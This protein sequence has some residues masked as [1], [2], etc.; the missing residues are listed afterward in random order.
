MLVQG[1]VAGILMLPVRPWT[2]V[3]ISTLIV[4]IDV[5]T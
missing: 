4:T 1:G 3:Y 5:C 2:K